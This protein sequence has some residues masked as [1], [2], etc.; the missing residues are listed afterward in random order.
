MPALGTTQRDLLLYQPMNWV[1]NN[2]C[3]RSGVGEAYIFLVQANRQHFVHHAKHSLSYRA[4]FSIILSCPALMQQHL[5]S[6]PPVAP[7]KAAS[8]IVQHI[9]SSH[10]TATW[11]AHLKNVVQHLIVSCSASP[12]PTCFVSTAILHEKPFICSSRPHPPQ[13]QQCPWDSLSTSW[14]ASATSQAHL[15]NRP[16]VKSR[17]LRGNLRMSHLGLKCKGFSAV[18]TAAEPDAMRQDFHA[19]DLVNP[20]HWQA[21]CA[22]TGCVGTLNSCSCFCR[23]TAR[24]DSASCSCPSCMA[25]ASASPAQ[26]TSRS[27]PHLRHTAFSASLWTR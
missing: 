4:A 10:S 1:T 21:V 18:P 26:N 27:L 20:V 22:Q 16:A 11:L 25:A 9:V 24:D 2:V 19:A 13:P 14:R 8:T 7:C 6:G 23:M 15:P 3:M 12:R 17:A 5:R